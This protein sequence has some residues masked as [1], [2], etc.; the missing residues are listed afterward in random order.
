MV[1]FLLRAVI[2]TRIVQAANLN[3]AA[4]RFLTPK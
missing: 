2:A 3:V 4:A 1:N